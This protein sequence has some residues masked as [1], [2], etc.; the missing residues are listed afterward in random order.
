[1]RNA[2]YDKSH[3]SVVGIKTRYGAGQSEG[4]EFESREGQELSRLHIVQTCSGTHPASYPMGYR[5]LFPPGIKW[6]GRELTTHLQLVQRSIKRGSTHPPPN[7]PSW[8][9]V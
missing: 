8:R 2:L 5:G 7:T 9:S 4:S 6:S 3:G 1:M